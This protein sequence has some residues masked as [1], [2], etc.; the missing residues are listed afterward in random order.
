MAYYNPFQNL[1]LRIPERYRDHVNQFCQTQTEAHESGKKL[2]DAPFERYV[3][4]WFS[5][6][7][8]G[9]ANQERREVEDPHR[10]ITGEILSRDP[11]R[12]QILELVAMGL[13]EDPWIIEDPKEVIGIANELAAYG[14]PRLVA[15]LKEGSSKS[16][17][18][19]T[20][21]LLAG[22]YVIAPEGET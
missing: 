5:A 18:N 21:A 22:E 11:E 10:F 20:D 6:V 1:E 3:D 17:W 16:I 12:I 15:M 19:L 2:V 14:L 8:I 4:M 7:C 9:A 13:E